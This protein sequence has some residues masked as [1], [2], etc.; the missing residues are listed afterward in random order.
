[1]YFFIAST[2]CL[3]MWN[4]ILRVGIFFLEIVL[5]RNIANFTRMRIARE[6][7]S[8]SCSIDS[9]LLLLKQKT[10]LFNKW[11]DVVVSKVC[12]LLGMG[13]QR[14][15]HTSSFIK[16]NDI[17]AKDNKEDQLPKNS[18][19]RIRRSENLALILSLIY[20]LKLRYATYKI[21]ILPQLIPIVL[22]LRIKFLY[23]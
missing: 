11:G 5:L 7:R 21:N 22:I 2:I 23:I 1:M 8:E 13:I 17:I 6:S 20:Y 12:I 16:T 3:S 18:K 9:N 4:R 15:Q 10:V 19:W 14:V